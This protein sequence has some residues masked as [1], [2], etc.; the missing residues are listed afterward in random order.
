V[1][2]PHRVHLGDQRNAQSGICLRN[3][4]CGSQTRTPGPH[5]CDVALEE[6]HIVFRILLSCASAVAC[7]MRGP[8]GWGLRSSASAP[9]GGSDTAGWRSGARIGCDAGSKKA[10]FHDRS[11]CAVAHRDD[12]IRHATRLVDVRLWSIH[13]LI[14]CC[15]VSSRRAV[16]APGQC[17]P[18]SA[19]GVDASQDGFF[20]P[21]ER[22][23]RLGAPVRTRRRGFAAPDGCREAFRL[24]KR[25]SGHSLLVF[26]PHL[27]HAGQSVRE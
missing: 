1:W 2:L 27:H 13:R 15:A 3:R 10:G 11:N 21:M 12:A 24:I 26:A 8:R 25:A 5:D 18:I 19:R 14:P 6:F 16:H 7:A 9:K 4:N 22:T 23:P 20:C 17:V